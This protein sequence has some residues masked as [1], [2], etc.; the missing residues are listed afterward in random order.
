M[1]RCD[2]TLFSFIV[3]L[4]NCSLDRVINLLQNIISMIFC[5]VYQCERK[6]VRATLVKGNL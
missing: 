6:T 4:H 2:L 3:C 1:N 5:F